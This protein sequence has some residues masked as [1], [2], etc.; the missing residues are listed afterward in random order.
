MYVVVV[1]KNNKEK[2]EAFACK[3][4]KDG[5]KKMEEVFMELVKKTK[6]LDKYRTRMSADERYAEVWSMMEVTKLRV[7]KVA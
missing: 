3:N 5:I 6:M 4:E 2:G 7:M 1:T